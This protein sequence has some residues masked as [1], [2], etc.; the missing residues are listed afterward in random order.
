M[1]F[2]DD[3]TLVR[4]DHFDHIFNGKDDEIICLRGEPIHLEHAP[5]F[6]KYYIWHDQWPVVYDIP[7]YCNGQ[8]M[9]ATAQ[10]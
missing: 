10:R 9:A 1:A 2:I 6:G 3:D 5:Y 8:C 4:L 7:P